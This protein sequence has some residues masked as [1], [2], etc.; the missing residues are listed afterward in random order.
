MILLLRFYILLLILLVFFLE[1]VIES[2]LD[3]DELAIKNEYFH[4]FI[5]IN[6]LLEILFSILFTKYFLKFILKK[7]FRFQNYPIFIFQII[8]WIIHYK[9][10]DILFS[11]KYLRCYNKSSRIS[12]ICIDW[13]DLNILYLELLMISF[14]TLHRSNQNIH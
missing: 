3:T 10:R 6:F 1:E 7:Y 8:N 5:M 12:F 2:I 9:K 13:Y 11:S 4:R 14:N